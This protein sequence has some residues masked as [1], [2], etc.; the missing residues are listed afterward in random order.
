MFNEF[1]TN[2]FSKHNSQN[3]V[4]DTQ[5]KNSSF[6]LFYNFSEKKFKIFKKFLNKHLKNEFI[7]SS[8]SICVALILFIKK[9]NE[10]YL[11]VDYRELNAIIVKN[12]YFLSFINKTLNWIINVKYFIKLNIITAYNKLRIKKKHEWKTT[13]CTRYD[14]YEYDVVFFKLANKLIAFQT[15]INVAFREYFNICAF[16]YIDD[17]F[18]FSKTF[19]KHKKHV[20]AILKRSLQ[21]KLY[22]D[23]K[24]LKFNVIKTS[25][26]KFIINCENFK[27]NSNKIEIIVD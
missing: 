23:I 17:I 18:I 11:C 26:L 6:K 4:I 3:L 2:I 24:K 9:T 1:V 20:R 10:L 8:K 7:F 12:R 16:V 25:F 15:Y 13:F 14:M 21:Y 19:K 5:N 22:V 27:I